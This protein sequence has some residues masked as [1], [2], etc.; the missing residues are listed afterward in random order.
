MWLRI[1]SAELEPQSVLAP[2]KPN[3]KSCERAPRKSVWPED[4]L[5]LTVTPNHY[6]TVNGLSFNTFVLFW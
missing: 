2:Q 5:Y 1:W 3:Q 6:I 4:T